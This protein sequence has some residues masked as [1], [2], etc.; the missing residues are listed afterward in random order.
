LVVVPELATEHVMGSTFYGIVVAAIVALP[1]APVRAQ[2]GAAS[3]GPRNSDQVQ[4]VQPQ[5]QQQPPQY[6]PQVQDPKQQPQQQPQAQDSNQNP[7]AEPDYHRFVFHRV[8]GT[9]LRLDM[10]TGAVDLCAPGGNEWACV[11][12]RDDRAALDREIARLQ[13]DNAVLKSAL[14]EHGVPLPAGMTP[15]P[16]GTGSWWNGDETIPRPP[17]T[18]PPTA[19]APGAPAGEAQESTAQDHPVQAP[20]HA[21][22]NDIDRALDAVE[23]G[24]RRLVEIMTNLKREMEK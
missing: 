11:P 8:D 10:R 2:E 24:W 22:E 23:R 16:P 20:A 18:I 14:L 4:P 15:N 7:N 9:M 1:Q 21:P 19:A 5:Q 17:Q 6:Q 13:R 3:P 12:G